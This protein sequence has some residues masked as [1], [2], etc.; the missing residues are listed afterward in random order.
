LGLLYF[1]I[2]TEEN[3]FVPIKKITHD[4][5]KQIYYINFPLRL[6]EKFSIIQKQILYLFFTLDSLEEIDL[7]LMSTFKFLQKI[8]QDEPKNYSIHVETSMDKSLSKSSFD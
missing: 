7:K 5:E 2:L 8:N 4:E 6:F 1:Y 3:Y